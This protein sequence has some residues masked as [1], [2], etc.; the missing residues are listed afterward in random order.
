MHGT[1]AERV[2]SSRCQGQGILDARGRFS[3]PKISS[4]ARQNKVVSSLLIFI[5]FFSSF[6]LYGLFVSCFVT[7]C[8]FVYLKKREEREEREERE[9]KVKKNFLLNVCISIFFVVLL[10]LLFSSFFFFTGHLLEDFYLVELV[11]NVVSVG[12]II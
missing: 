10:F 3:S 8:I 2:E 12:I 6:S 5:S 9:V 7:V 1:L 4:R 11:N